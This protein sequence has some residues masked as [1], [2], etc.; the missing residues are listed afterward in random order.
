MHHPVI[1][2]ALVALMLAAGHAGVSAAHPAAKP[3]G[4]G[5]LGI[6]SG[7]MPVVATVERGATSCA[8]AKKVLRSY[9][10]SKAP[11]SGSACVREHS[12][13]TC[14]SAK[15]ADWPRVASCSKAKNVIVAYNPAD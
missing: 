13:W 3:R 5:S 9:L 7:G 11:C 12:G 1:R 8:T 4:C 14:A 10:R 15:S 2:I 6:K